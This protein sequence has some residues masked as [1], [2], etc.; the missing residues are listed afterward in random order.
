[1]NKK[2]FSGVGSRETPPD[3]CSQMTT[4]A[5][6]LTHNKGYIL[7]SGHADGADIAFEG[8]LEDQYKE[9]YIPWKGFNGSYSRLFYIT[10]EAFQLASTIHPAWN[11]CKPAAKRLHARNTYQVL[12]ETLRT[13][14]DFLLCWT[15]DACVS[16]K[17]RTRNTGGTATAIVLAD[18][19]NIPV[20]NMRNP[21]WIDLF[22]GTFPDLF[23]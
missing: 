4:I 8:E 7:R 19:I 14:S 22:E 21:G 11:A 2:Y 13:P 20:F 5:K 9:I 17:T 18:R 15:E 12:G 10:D 16:E 3:I 1:M 23:R 6:H